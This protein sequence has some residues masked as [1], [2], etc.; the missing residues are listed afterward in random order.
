MSN[1]KIQKTVV[2]I[3]IAIMIISTFAFGLAMFN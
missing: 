3:M 2:Y 1:K